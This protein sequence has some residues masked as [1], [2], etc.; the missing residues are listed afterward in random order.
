M[1]AKSNQ[2]IILEYE[3]YL[4]YVIEGGFQAEYYIQKNSENKE[5][6]EKNRIIYYEKLFNVII[7]P[8]INQF[9]ELKLSPADASVV[10]LR[11]LEIVSEECQRAELNHKPKEESKYPNHWANTKEGNV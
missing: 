2:E 7:K 11:L 10:V 5:T 9:E 6:H 4:G 3:K 1:D 8:I